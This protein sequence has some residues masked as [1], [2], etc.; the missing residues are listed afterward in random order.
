MLYSIN[1]ILVVSYI[2]TLNVLADFT[3]TSKFG[4]QAHRKNEVADLYAKEFE[5]PLPSQSEEASIN[6]QMFVSPTIHDIVDSNAI[7]NI[8][9]VNPA[10]MSSHG[11]MSAYL[12]KTPLNCQCNSMQKQ[13]QMSAYLHPLLRQILRKL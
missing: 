8:I 4:D 13:W 7:E 9:S 11:Y 6:I 10:N 12:P 2:W 1:S 5:L 3:C